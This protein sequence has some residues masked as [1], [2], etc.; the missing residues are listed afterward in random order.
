MEIIK[1]SDNLINNF[2]LFDNFIKWIYKY[3]YI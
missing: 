3:I 1:F 2:E